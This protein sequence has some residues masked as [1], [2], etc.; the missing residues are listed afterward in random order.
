MKEIKDYDI[1]QDRDYDEK[2]SNGIWDLAGDLLDSEL[3]QETLYNY[4]Q[5]FKDA[6]C[7]KIRSDL[8]S[9]LKKF[10]PKPDDVLTQ[11]IYN[12]DNKLDQNQKEFEDEQD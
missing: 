4:L 8:Q 1:M 5:D 6:V 3:E 10:K 12:L 7:E 2:Y 9:G 11:F